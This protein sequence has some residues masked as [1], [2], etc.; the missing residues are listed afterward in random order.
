[1]KACGIIVEYNPFHN[2]HIYHIQKAQEASQAEVVV[3][4]M[5]GNFLQRGEPAIIDKWKRAEEALSNG[6]DLVIELPAEWAVQSADY[7]A[8][9][10]VKL[11]HALKCQYLCFGT[12]SSGEVDYQAFGQFSANN[13]QLIEEK[14]KE[15]ADKRLSYPQQMTAVYQA[16]YPELPLDFSSPNHI[17]GLSYAKENALYKEPM[18]LLPINRKGAHYNEVN[19]QPRFSSATAIRKAVLT[20]HFSEIE[21][22]VP[23]QTSND[24]AQGPLVSW[25][26]YWPL[27]Q[28]KL[29]STSIEELQLV[30]QMNEGLEYR[31]KEMAVRAENFQQFIELV[32]T[33][34]YTWTRLQRLAVYTLLNSSNEAVQQGWDNSYLRVLGMTE[35]G[36]KYLS[37]HKKD[38]ELPLLT[39]QAKSME[40]LFAA[41][42]TND[43]I[44]QLGHAE[45]SEQSQGRFPIRIK[46][47]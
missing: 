4:V 47:A 33:K 15:L 42:L 1:M 9:G 25:E 26:N 31:L 40:Q 35:A 34:R 30:Y 18:K 37:V 23:K 28:Y 17:L 13:Q 32:K 14:Y 46:K 5:S 12:D 19:L 44:Y 41:G 39:R 29:I 2:G 11:L 38:F 20:K 3:A 36:Q 45:I 8:R 10:G 16:L 6:V 7:F 21:T 22:T 43:R 24:L 27:L